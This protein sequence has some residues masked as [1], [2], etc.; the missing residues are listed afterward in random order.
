MLDE[1]ELAD[2]IIGRISLEWFVVLD[3]PRRLEILGER[4]LFPGFPPIEVRKTNTMFQYRHDHHLSGSAAGDAAPVMVSA[5][6]AG[7]AAGNYS[8][9]PDER[10]LYHAATLHTAA[11]KIS[12]GCKGS[13]SAPA[14][15]PCT[16]SCTGFSFADIG[17]N[18]PSEVT[19][20]GGTSSPMA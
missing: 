9:V 14:I 20:D 3:A 10:K 5:T 8:A 19:I 18:S 7:A 12:T 17:S 15:T 4:G 6:I 2:C 11:W 16:S 1:H 13:E